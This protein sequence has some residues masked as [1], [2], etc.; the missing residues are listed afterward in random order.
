MQLSHC[1]SDLALEAFANGELDDSVAELTRAHLTSCQSCR[2]RHE[3]Q[4]RERAEF[5]ATAPTFEVHAQR[6]VAP[7]RR[8]SFIAGGL[9]VA[10]MAAA[11]L[12]VVFGTPSETRLKGQPSIGFYV[13]RGDHVRESDGMISLR[14]GDLLRFTYTSDRD[15]YFALFDR[16]PRSASIF[17]P[18]GQRAMLLRAG[19]DVPLQ[20][21]VE[22][23]DTPGVETVH[24][25]FCSESF[26]LEPLRA[27]L[28]Q[29]RRLPVP[30][31][32]HEDTRT[33]NREAAK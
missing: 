10:A 5:Y 8:R 31:G 33:L 6:F 13:K 1:P 24:A 3:V 30:A 28:E 32:C 26:E 4:A 27:A 23:D 20:F 22:L 9:A 7:R 12:L 21:S 17:Y 18:Q 2:L 15:R 11:A 14:P 29:T 16:D 25:L 19:R